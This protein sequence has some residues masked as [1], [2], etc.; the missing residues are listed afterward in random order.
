MGRVP[1]LAAER[2]AVMSG[3]VIEVAETVRRVFEA[4]WR[5]AVGA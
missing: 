5:L 2:G 4:V 3:G 1:G